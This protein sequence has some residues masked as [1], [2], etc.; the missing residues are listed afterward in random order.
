MKWRG[1]PSWFPEG[2]EGRVTYKGQL[3]NLVIQL[4]G[5]LQAGMGYCGCRSIAEMKERTQFIRISP[6]GLRERHVHDVFIT[7]ESPNYQIE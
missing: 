3:A 4:V 1:R 2:I 5:G 7:K 6:A